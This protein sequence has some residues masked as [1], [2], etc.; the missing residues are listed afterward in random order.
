M[1]ISTVSSDVAPKDIPALPPPLPSRSLKYKSATN[2]IGGWRF[3]MG[4]Q[5]ICLIFLS[6][7]HVFGDYPKLFTPRLRKTIRTIVFRLDHYFIYHWSIGYF[8]GNLFILWGSN[9][10]KCNNGQ[11]S[12]F[13]T[14]M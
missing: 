1:E 13:G 7:W 6:L 5:F 12:F 2:S 3:I 10:A 11:F 14:G 9:A 4:I 8:G